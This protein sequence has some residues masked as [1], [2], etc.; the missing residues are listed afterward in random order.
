MIH[1]CERKSALV[2]VGVVNLPYFDHRLGV[3]NALDLNPRPTREFQVS[4][5][6]RSSWRSVRH[7]PPSHARPPGHALANND[8]NNQS[9]PKDDVAAAFE[10]PVLCLAFG[11]FGLG[12]GSPDVTLLLE[13]QQQVS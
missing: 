11:G 8:D 7:A 6:S 3:H 2:V 13:L 9:C 12:L 10:G 1:A 5:A 4:D